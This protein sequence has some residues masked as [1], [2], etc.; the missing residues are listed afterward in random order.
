MHM[1]TSVQIQSL[2]FTPR[3]N[4]CNFEKTDP[5]NVV[6]TRIESTRL[7]WTYLLVIIVFH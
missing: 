1:A 7:I 2:N 5:V 4:F 6:F 3:Q